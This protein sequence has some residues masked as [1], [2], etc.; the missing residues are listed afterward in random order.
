[1]KKVLLSVVLLSGVLFA[2]EHIQ[3]DR[4]KNMQEMETALSTIQKGFLFNNLNVVKNGVKDLKVTTMHTESFIKEG[5]TK[6]GFNTLVY[7]KK[8]AKDIT[9]LSSKILI[10]FEKGDRYAAANNYL[11]ILSKCLSCHQ[12]VRSW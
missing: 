4:M 12:T 10:S 11:Q 6:E 1:M 7:A 3:P 8:Q 5:V 2:Q 9:E